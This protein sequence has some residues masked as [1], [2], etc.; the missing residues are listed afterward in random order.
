MGKVRH[1]LS[2]CHV[3]SVL[4]VVCRC[5]CVSVGTHEPWKVCK[6]QI[7]HA[8]LK[9]EHLTLY[10]VLSSQGWSLA[11]DCTIPVCTCDMA[12]DGFVNMALRVIIAY[13]DCSFLI[14]CRTLTFGTGVFNGLYHPA[15][16]WLLY[17]TL[18]LPDCSSRWKLILLYLA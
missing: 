4:R 3:I 13:K 7:C 2:L 11:L 8:Q 10:L 12:V 6:G 1:V 5:V 18:C 9:K 15:K 17:G 14:V 16:A